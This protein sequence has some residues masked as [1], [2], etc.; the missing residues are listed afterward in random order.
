MTVKF[1]S[2][3]WVRSDFAFFQLVPTS[4]MQEQ[5]HLTPE[6]AENARRERNRESAKQCRKRRKLREE[7]LS[8]SFQRL[9]CENTGLREF[10]DKLL[11]KIKVYEQK[12]PKEAWVDEDGLPMYKTNEVEDRPSA[13]VPFAAVNVSITARI[14]K[15][16]QTD[17]CSTWPVDDATGFVESL[18]N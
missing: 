17:N 12:L 3:Q 11:R 5:A 16:S 6:E 4:Y 2:V 9:Y 8:D 7:N 14:P 15:T 1:N 18:L 13:F 10:V